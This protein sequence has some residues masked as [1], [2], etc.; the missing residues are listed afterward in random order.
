MTEG[1]PADAACTHPLDR[2]KCTLGVLA[3]MLVYERFRTTNISGSDP[4][5]DDAHAAPSWHG[6]SA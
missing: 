5:R 1:L 4:L 3:D 6:C 2:L